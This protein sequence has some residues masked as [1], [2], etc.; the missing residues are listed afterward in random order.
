M[1][2]IFGIVRWWHHGNG[3]HIHVLEEEERLRRVIEESTEASRRAK[4]AA[5]IHT[6]RTNGLIK[7]LEKSIDA[8]KRGQ[9]EDDN[10]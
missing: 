1:N 4:I 9:E 6:D 5:E 2:L 10:S 7:T 3:D 8:I